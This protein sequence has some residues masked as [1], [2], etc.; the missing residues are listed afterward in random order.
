MRF[1]PR[2][3]LRRIKKQRENGPRLPVVSTTLL[4][5][6]VLWLVVVLI[7]L[8]STIPTPNKI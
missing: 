1:F 5:L 7:C 2:P 6:A 3:L 4:V 8:L